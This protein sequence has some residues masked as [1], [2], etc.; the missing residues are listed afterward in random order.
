MKDAKHPHLLFDDEKIK[1]LQ[2][3]LLDQLLGEAIV[4]NGTER[5]IPGYKEIEE[6]LFHLA[7]TF[8]RNSDDGDELVKFPSVKL[9]HVLFTISAKPH[10]GRRGDIITSYLPGDVALHKLHVREISLLMLKRYLNVIKQVRTGDDTLYN[11]FITVVQQIIRRKTTFTSHRLVS[12]PKMSPQSPRKNDIISLMK[13]TE[14]SESENEVV[15]DSDSEGD[16]LKTSIEE[17]VMKYR[18]YF[19]SPTKSAS[20]HSLV[21]GKASDLFKNVSY[22][23]SPEK[24]DITTDIDSSPTKPR[25]KARSLSPAKKGPKSSSPGKKGP[26]SSSPGRRLPRS[27]SPLKPVPVEEELHNIKIMDELLLAC[28]LRNTPNYN[29]WKLLQWTLICAER[30]SKSGSYNNHLI[31]RSYSAFFHF[32]V[33]FL[34]YNLT[35]ETERL[36][37]QQTSSRRSTVIKLILTDSRILLL[38]LMSHLSTSTKEWSDRAVEFVFTGLNIET[39]FEPQPLYEREKVFARDRQDREMA[40]A[41]QRQTNENLQPW[42]D[43]MDSMSLRSKII[44]LLYYRLELMKQLSEDSGAEPEMFIRLTSSKLMIID[45]TLFEAFFDSP[46]LAGVPDQVYYQLV[47]KLMNQIISEITQLVELYDYFLEAED[48]AK[49]KVNKFSVLIVQDDLYS[50]TEDDHDAANWRRLNYILVY[51]MNRVMIEVNN[52]EWI[53]QLRSASNAA[54]DLRK[55][56]GTDFVLFTDLHD[57]HYTK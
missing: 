19:L 26:R 43:N 44:A 18:D 37:S 4:Y 51:M 7:T 45:P 15:S 57:F 46:V 40:L 31:Y 28:Q 39:T 56:Y 2:T 25:A 22:L 34:K 13:K 11:R 32:L 41:R 16:V 24:E 17:E 8:S 50:W 47:W 48:L 38:L 1:L 29:L 12:K 36:F 23:S 6:V 30:S 10:H 33:D 3:Q 5:N 55:K 14:Q 54:D 49:N 21:V 42:N 27:A 52:E 35:F 20:S 53:E 9:L